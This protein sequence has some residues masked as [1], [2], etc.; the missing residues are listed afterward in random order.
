MA[1]GFLSVTPDMEGDAGMVQ[2][3][4]DKVLFLGVNGR[5]G[6]ILVHT[7]TDVFYTTG[8]LKYWTHVLNQSGYDFVLADRNNS[9]NLRNIYDINPILKLAYFDKDD[10]S[11]FCTMSSSGLKEVKDGLLSLNLPILLC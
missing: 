1:M 6:I 3:P 7:L 8:T 2:L 9:I 11:K 5:S 4:L 10:R